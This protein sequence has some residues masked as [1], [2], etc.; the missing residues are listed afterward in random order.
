[1]TI[2]IYV[3]S[4]DLL[5]GL[6]PHGDADTLAYHFAMP[7]LMSETGGIVFT[8][9]AVDGAVPLLIQMTYVPMLLIGGALAS[10]YCGIHFTVP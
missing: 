7:K 6:L 8:P 10:I 4:L 9:R 3:Y 1:M 5:E 2:I